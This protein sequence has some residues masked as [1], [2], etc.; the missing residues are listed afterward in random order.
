MK[1]KINNQWLWH[2]SIQIYMNTRQPPFRPELGWSSAFHSKA[3]PFFSRAWL[4]TS[5][6]IAKYKYFARAKLWKGKKRKG[7]NR[8][9]LSSNNKVVWTFISL[10]I[11]YK[12]LF[13]EESKWLVTPG[14]LCNYSACFANC[15][16][17]PKSMGK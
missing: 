17:N 12:P 4:W 13:E 15:T 5:K 3:G 7:M 8:D 6:A 1:F 10:W 16:S 11:K 14:Y 9:N 2:S